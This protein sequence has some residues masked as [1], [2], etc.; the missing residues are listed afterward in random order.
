MV[1]PHQD[2]L[3]NQLLASLSKD[4]FER[5][6]PHLEQVDMPRLFSLSAPHRLSDDSYFVESGIGSIVAKYRRLV[7]PTSDPAVHSETLT[8]L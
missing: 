6:A 5:L 1:S 7:G 2:A 3:R 4:D 8:Q